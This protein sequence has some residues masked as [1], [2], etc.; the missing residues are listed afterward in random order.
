MK[1]ASSTRLLTLTLLLLGATSGFAQNTAPAASQP[2]L[3]LATVTPSYPY[4]MRHAGATAEVTVAIS[5]DAKGAVTK[6]NVVNSSNFEFNEATLAA[7]K[8]WTFTPALKDGRPVAAQLKQTFYF[9]VR[10]QAEV[11]TKTML[12]G[13]P[14]SR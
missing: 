11:T 2:A 6:A 7:I 1:N 12:A 5:V 9:S 3:P 13:S 8:K 10:D 4:L 14:S